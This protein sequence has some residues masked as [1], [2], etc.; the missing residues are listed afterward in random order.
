MARRSATPALK[1]LDK[2]QTFQIAEM[3]KEGV[4]MVRESVANNM[5]R[6]DAR[7]AMLDQVTQEA[8]RRGLNVAE[9]AL[10]A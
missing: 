5:F 7:M 9:L 8:V 1:N 4:R 2:K 10:A 3:V 6:Y